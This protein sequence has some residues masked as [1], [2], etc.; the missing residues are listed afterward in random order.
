MRQLNFDRLTDVDVS[1]SLATP[2]WQLAEWLYRHGTEEERAALRG[3]QERVDR[4]MGDTQRSLRQEMEGYHVM[5]D[6][7]MERHIDELVQGLPAP[8]RAETNQRA[9]DAAMDKLGQDQC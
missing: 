5:L 6:Q 4:L 1:C 9:H 7:A 3:S 8:L 2:K